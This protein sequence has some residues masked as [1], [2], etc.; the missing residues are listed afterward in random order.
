MSQST[1]TVNSENS[2]PCGT[3]P[4]SQG[5]ASPQGELVSHGMDIKAAACDSL[6]SHKM[7]VAGYVYPCPY[8]PYAMAPPVFAAGKCRSVPPPSAACLSVKQ[9]TIQLQLHPRPLSILISIITT[10]VLSSNIAVFIVIRFR[11]RFL[12]DQTR[13][14]CY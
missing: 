1:S 7:T 4:S 12:L 2:S 13:G 11:T 8:P 14:Y 5:P 3:G 10:T 9:S 6:D